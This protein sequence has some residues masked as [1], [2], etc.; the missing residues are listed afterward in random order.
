MCSLQCVYYSVLS[1]HTNTQYMTIMLLY[2]DDT[3]ICKAVYKIE[4]V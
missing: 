4:N 3:Y 2:I 1:T